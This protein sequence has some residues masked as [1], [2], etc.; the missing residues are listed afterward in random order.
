LP[1]AAG[2]R[3]VRN[4]KPLISPR[5]RRP[6]LTGQTFAGSNG[7]RAMT[8]RSSFPDGSR[9]ARKV[10]RIAAIFLTARFA[11][12]VP[13]RISVPVGLQRISPAWRRIKLGLR[14]MRPCSSS[15]AYGNSSVSKGHSSSRA[16]SCPKRVR[17]VIRGASQKRSRGCSLLA[18][19]NGETEIAGYSSSCFLDNR[20]PAICRWGQGEQPKKV[21]NARRKSIFSPRREDMMFRIFNLQI[22]EGESKAKQILQNRPFPLRKPS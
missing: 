6:F 9:R 16:V 13:A 21:K 4:A 15:E 20:R 2:K 8:Q 14:G 18:C 7:T 1:P 11:T 10:L 22:L 3:E 19:H 5:T 12:Y 17:F